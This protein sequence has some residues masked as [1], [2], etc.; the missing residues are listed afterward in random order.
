MEL[1][2]IAK[3]PGRPRTGKA[4][5][6]AQRMKAY[7]ARKA[8]ELSSRVTEINNPMPVQGLSESGESNG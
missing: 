3:R 2:G 6:G 8:V 7:R 5:T 4:K 1:P